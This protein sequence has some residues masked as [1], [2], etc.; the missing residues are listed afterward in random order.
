V[1]AAIGAAAVE[2]AAT[3]TWLGRTFSW[4]LRRELRP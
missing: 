2:A 3:V 1:A 4:Q